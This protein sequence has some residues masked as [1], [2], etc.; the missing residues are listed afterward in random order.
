M[1][2]AA[3][4]PVRYEDLE[5]GAFFRA[6]SDFGVPYQKREYNGPIGRTTKGYNT[7]TGKMEHCFGLVYR[8]EPVTDERIAHEQA[9]HQMWGQIAANH[10]C[11]LKADIA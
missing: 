10:D 5:I 1:N 2:T 6:E 3:V 9:D 7:R 11:I 8:C 4:Q